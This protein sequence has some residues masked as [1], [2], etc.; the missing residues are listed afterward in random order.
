VLEQTHGHEQQAHA[1][2][3]GQPGAQ[4]PDTWRVVC[5]HELRVHLSLCSIQQSHRRHLK[6]RFRYTILCNC[7]KVGPHTRLCRQPNHVSRCIALSNEASRGCCSVLVRA[8]RAT[9]ASP[10]VRHVKRYLPLV[11]HRRPAQDASG[12]PQPQIRIRFLMWRSCGFQLR[13]MPEQVKLAQVGSYNLTYM[14]HTPANVFPRCSSKFG[15]TAGCPSGPRGS[16]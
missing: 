13:H 7:N 11:H 16:T 14:R 1:A 8:A 5:C 3:C 2:T 9:E 15:L 10:I 12:L 6:S 4:T